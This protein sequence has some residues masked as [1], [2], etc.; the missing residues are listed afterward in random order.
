LLIKN[1]LIVTVDPER[2]VISNGAILIEDNRIVDVGK[3]E[4][5]EKKYDPEIIID[6]H[7]KIVLP[8]FIDAHNHIFLGILRF[9]RAREK[10][11]RKYYWDID[12]FKQIGEKECYSSGLL[13]AVTML[14]SGVTCTQDSHFINFQK[15]DV[16]GIAQSAIDTGIRIVLGKGCWD[17]PDLVSDEYITDIAVQRRESEDVILKWHGKGDERIQIRIEPSMLSQCTDELILTIKELANKYKV[18][19]ATHIQY[20]LGEA[21]YCTRKNG[22]S[23][24]RYGGRA[25]EYLDDLGVL[26]PDNLLIHC[27]YINNREIDLL[28]KSNTPV[29]HCPAGNMLKGIP[30][31]TPV[32]YMMEKGIPVGL[33]TDSAVNMFQLMKSCTQIHKQNLGDPSVLP[34]GKIIELSTIYAAKVL[35]LESEI[36]SIE[37]GKKADITIMNMNSSKPSSL[38]PI[39]EI[40]NSLDNS[41][42][43][44]TVIIDGKIVMKNKKILIFN[45]TEALKSSK[46]ASEKIA[47]LSGYLNQAAEIIVP[48][49]WK[50]I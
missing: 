37:V 24:K 33:G 47:R 36:G 50:Y 34:P 38:Q 26:G 14:R 25:I 21:P 16:D 6:A 7:G 29:A 49:Q 23:I 27:Y 20:R 8:G 18:S 9:V 22:P 17:V 15:N 39:Y 3:T 10:K 45:E 5:I 11:I 43:V 31:V 40:V 12:V 19:M 4:K 13:N 32:P 44:E 30:R 41:S 46:K 2:R 1:G 35:Q 42:L 28:S 48:P